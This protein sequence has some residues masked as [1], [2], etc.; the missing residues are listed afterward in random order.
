MM[1]MIVIINETKRGAWRRCRGPLDLIYIYIYIYVYTH[2]TYIYIYIYNTHYIYIY[3]ERDCVDACRPASRPARRPARRLHANLQKI[4]M[5]CVCSA[6]EW[7][8][9]SK[10]T[11]YVERQS[12]CWAWLAATRLHSRLLQSSTGC[13]DIHSSG[14]HGCRWPRVCLCLEM[15][16]KATVCRTCATGVT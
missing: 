1:I 16:W 9:L 3:I 4:G 15:L 7:P 2:T 13:C 11:V 6:R 8:V 14:R 10:K 12:G 5:S